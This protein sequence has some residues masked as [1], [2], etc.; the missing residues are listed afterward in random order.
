M[1]I[2]Q[3]QDRQ[4]IRQAIGFNLND[5]I[6]S[7]VTDTKDTSSL[8]DTY[9]LSRGGDDEY[10]GRQVIIYDATGS[11]TDGEKSFVS[12]FVAASADATMSPAFTQN[13]TDGDKY[14]MWRTFLV[15]EVN[16]AINQAIIEI[17][18]RALIDRQ[19]DTNFTLSN[20]Y[21]YDWLVPYAFGLDFKGLNKVEYVDALGIYHVINNC[22]TVWDDPDT[23]VTATRDKTYKIE[24]DYCEK[25]VVADA[26]AAGDILATDTIEEVDISDCDEL[27]VFVRSTVALDAGDLQVLLD[28]TAA[29]ASPLESL[30]IPAT[31][32]NTDT[33][34]VI[35][36][37]NPHSDTAIISVGIKMVTDKG[38][39]TLYADR[40]RVVKGDSK[41]YKPL[42][43]ELWSIVKGTTPKLR[44]TDDALELVGVNTQI[45]LSGLCAPDIFTDDTTDSEVDPAWI[46]AKVTSKLLIAHAKS[47]R[48]DIR[49]RAGLS[50]EWRDQAEKLKPNTNIAIN[51]RW[52]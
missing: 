32:A 3:L 39:F 21:E 37:A 41:V 40:I 51:T 27:E 36:L 17:T 8:W 22:E 14:E 38:A 1:G 16:D 42:N 9:G 25:L 26:C 34:H 44:L 30:D 24:G 5:M 31:S 48:L 23:D 11:I 35:D 20:V 46:I 43:S 47:P 10:N 6:L 12:D 4:E 13:L 2:F 15:E 19:T 49:D 50:K 29:C 45:R 52:V 28:D 33:H 18:S 7:E